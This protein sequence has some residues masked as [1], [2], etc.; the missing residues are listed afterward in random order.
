MKKIVRLPL[1]NSSI[2]FVLAALLVTTIHE[3]SHLIVSLFLGVPASIY[4]NFVNSTVHVA[5][6]QAILIAGTGPL[7]SLVSGLLVILLIKKWLKRKSNTFIK[8]VVLWFG[9]LSAETGF[10]Y[11]FIA[12]LVAGGDTGQV[13]ALLHAHWL[14]YAVIFAIGVAG[15]VLLLPRLLSAR[16]SQF[17]HNKASFFQLSMFPWLIGTGILL[18]IY[19]L[20][21]TVTSLNGIDNPGL[22]ALMGVATIGVFAPMADYHKKY[23]DTNAMQSTFSFPIAGIIITVILALFI[24]F[25]LSR[26][27]YFGV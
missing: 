21:I 14:V 9:F 12:P 3:C 8:L 10:G 22:I 20:S 23:V 26:G 15:F 2:A 13:L 25:V 24:I 4:P 11:F 1:I 5:D 27:I 17:A 19:V 18:I 7:F 6:W 16:L